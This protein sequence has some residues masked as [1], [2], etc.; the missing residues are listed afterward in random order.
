MAP[1]KNKKR[2]EKM[3]DIPYGP[4]CYHSS[5]KDHT[6]RTCPFHT[7]RLTNFGSKNRKTAF[8]YCKYLRTYL[9]IQ[10][11]CKDCR[12]RPEDECSNG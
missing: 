1:F 5:G 2:A 9:R 6:Y 8:E 12:I 7:Y 11:E 10:D 4:Y 3:K